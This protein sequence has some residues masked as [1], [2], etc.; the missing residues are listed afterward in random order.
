[1]SIEPTEQR[2]YKVDRSAT[3]KQRVLNKIDV[4]ALKI[5]ERFSDD[6]DPYNS[7][8]QHLVDAIKDRKREE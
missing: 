1:M 2:H 6:C 7:T 5:D 8:G 3:S 4:S